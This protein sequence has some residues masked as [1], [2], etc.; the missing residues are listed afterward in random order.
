[1]NPF[2]YWYQTNKAVKKYIDDYYKENS[3]LLEQ[4][5]KIFASAEK[6]M[7]QGTAREKTM[8]VSLLASIKEFG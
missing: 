2:D 4:Y 6:V 3:L 7:N 5:P 8:V 1:M